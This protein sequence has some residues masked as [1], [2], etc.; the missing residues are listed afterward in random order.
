MGEAIL[1]HPR[2][3]GVFPKVDLVRPDGH[4]YLLAAAVVDRR[5]P[6]AFVWESARKKG[7]LAKLK[8]H[9]EAVRALPGVRGITLYKARLIPP[10]RGRFLK[11]RPAA[12]VAPYDV[13]VLVEADSPAAAEAIGGMADWRALQSDMCGASKDVYTVVASNVKRIGSVDRTRDG[14]FLFNFFFADRLDQN[15]AV[16]EYTAGWFEDQTGLRNSTV[17]LPERVSDKTTRSSITADGIPCGISYRRWRSSGRS[18]LTC[19]R[20]SKQTIPQRSPFSTAWRERSKEAPACPL[21][22]RFNS[23]NGRW[24]LGCLPP[25]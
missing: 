21:I 4:G 15:L 23:N 19:L 22:V 25:H 11:Q 18:E 3:A 9:A 12:H 10:G 2:G 13:V 8:R 7:L 20:I 16:W 24:R 6:F 17:L 1:N 5:P 14:V